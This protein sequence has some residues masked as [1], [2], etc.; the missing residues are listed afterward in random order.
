MIQPNTPISAQEMLAISLE[1]NQDFAP[2]LYPEPP[3][4]I[5]LEPLSAQ[6]LLGISQIISS[7]FA[8]SLKNTQPEVVLMP[9]DPEHVH[10]YWNLPESDLIE[11]TNPEFT[12][13]LHPLA[14]THPDDPKYDW[15]DFFIN[16]RQDQQTLQLPNNTNSQ[17]YYASVSQTRFDQQALTLATSNITQ[18]PQHQSQANLVGNDKNITQLFQPVAKR[19]AVHRPSS[20]INNASG[21]NFTQ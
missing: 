6:E 15:L 4:Q 16:K 21:Q 17:H 11:A 10:A 2:K 7:G 13:S 3:K 5:E 1:I 9:I 19:C 8:P 12:L 14:D 20:L 18:V